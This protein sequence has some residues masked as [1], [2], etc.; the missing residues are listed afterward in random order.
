MRAHLFYFST[1]STLATM[2]VNTSAAVAALAAAKDVEALEA[3]IESASFLDNQ[4]GDDRQKLRGKGGWR[5]SRAAMRLP[6]WRAPWELRTPRARP[7]P[8]RSCPHQAQEDA[9]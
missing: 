8:A 4:P 6:P 1:N 9:G 5:G 7:M 2:V 3:A